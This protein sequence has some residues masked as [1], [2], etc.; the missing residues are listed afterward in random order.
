MKQR[1]NNLDGF[2]FISALT[3]I[4]THT[5]GIKNYFG[6][7]SV[8]AKFFNTSGHFAVSAFFVLSSF[9]I[10]WYLM[11]EK[12]KSATGKINIWH[13]YKKRIVRL[14]PLYYLLL[15]LTFCIFSKNSVFLPPQYSPVVDDPVL[16]M[17]RFL[18]YLFW[19]PNYTDLK[20]GFFFHMGQT[21]TLAV[22][23]FFYLF[24]PIAIL[25]TPYKK[26]PLMFISSAILFIIF[27]LAIIYLNKQYNNDTI[28]IIAFYA[29][30]YRLFS[31]CFGALAAYYCIP[32]NLRPEV[33]KL[34][35]HKWYS[36]I[37]LLI[38]TVVL[39]FGVTFSVFNHIVNSILFAMLIFIATINKTNYS[40]LNKKPIIYLGKISYG[41]YMFQPLVI[42]TTLQLIN[43]QIRGLDNFSCILISWSII[44]GIT[45]LLSA[46]SYELF[47]K[48]VMRFFLKK[49]RND[50]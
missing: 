48:K 20:V 14:W 27:S 11:Q 4:L 5:E 38:V 43:K 10:G 32:G 26:I 13:F 34:F 9:L 36:H 16:S 31:F 29:D 42:A 24:F 17:N 40:L 39:V 35:L 15:L 46:I 7:K 18:G 49:N 44:L 21:W 2:R 6:I 30:K 8:S 50:S 37:F 12:Q 45:F 28:G 19:L 3:I 22:E 41:I 47:E 1:I 33:L 23:E 25:I